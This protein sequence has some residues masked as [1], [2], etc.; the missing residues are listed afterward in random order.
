MGKRPDIRERIEAYRAR[1]DREGPEQSLLATR[2]ALA[3]RHPLLVARAAELAGD[4]LIYG[5]EPDLIAAFGRFLEDP[6]KRDPG[7]TAKG[8]IARALVAIDCQ[9]V[10]FYLTGIVYRQPEPVWGGSVDT[11]VDL[12]IACAMGLAA[13]A[14][15][16]ALI[17]L[18]GLLHDPEPHCRSGAARAIACTQPLAAEA[19]LRSK[20]LAGDPEPEVTGECLTAL[21]Q[22]AGEEALGFVA[23]LLDSRDGELGGLAALA[24]GESHLDG[25]LKLLRERWDAEPFKRERDRVLLRAAALHRSPAAID[26]LVE[27][28]AAGDPASAET[29]ILELGAFRSNRGLGERLAAALARHGAGRGEERLHAA[30]ERAFARSGRTPGPG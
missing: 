6:A 30:F 12:R 28:A 24:L 20:T 14:Y 29:A 4:R 16:R 26:W 23:G 13:T 15:P 3:E 25:A 9:Q 22:V 19:V 11:A 5:L 27:V 18:V 8:A 21:L 2:K 10:D 17:H 1:C 7:C